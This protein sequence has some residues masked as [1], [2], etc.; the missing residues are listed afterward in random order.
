M[1]TERLFR[2]KPLLVE[3][4]QWFQFGDHREVVPDEQNNPVLWSK[5]IAHK[6]NPG[7]WI[8]RD[9]EGDCYPCRPD[10]FAKQFQPVEDS[11][12]IKALF[13][14]FMDLEEAREYRAVFGG[15]LL[16]G[17]DCYVVCDEERAIELLCL[18]SLSFSDSK[19]K[20]KELQ[21]KGFD[22]TKIK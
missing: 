3:A 4:V 8:V 22:E 2:Q 10:F 14:T 20:I 17:N 21:V 18:R 1:H 11:Y 9:L 13:E 19:N 15:Y 7:D 12:Q 6:V 5:G 16:C